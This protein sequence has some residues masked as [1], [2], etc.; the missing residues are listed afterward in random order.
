M[1]PNAWLNLPHYRQEFPYSC[2]AAC[3]RMVLAYLGCQR[4]ESELRQLLDTKPSGTRVG[5]L[6][7]LGQLGF[8]VTLRASNLPQLRAALAA[9]QPVILFLESGPLD[10]WDL[11]VAHVVVLLGIDDT[12]GVP[13]R[14]L[15]RH[16]SPVHIVNQL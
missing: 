8:E 13:G 1:S 10:Y 15:L 2:L 11:D 16:S 12:T 3:A 9:N 14:P 4:T 5:N 6:V 7:R